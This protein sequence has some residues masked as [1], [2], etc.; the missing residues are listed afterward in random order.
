MANRKL[1]R[2]HRRRCGKSED[3]R[4]CHRGENN[5]DA[6]STRMHTDDDIVVTSTR[7]L[8]Q[9]CS[10]APPPAP[11]PSPRS[12]TPRRALSAVFSPPT[13]PRNQHDFSSSFF[14]AM[15]HASSRNAATQASS[16]AVSFTALERAH[17]T[18]AAP[19]ASANNHQHCASHPRSY[20]L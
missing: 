18:E 12:A 4:G 10:P 9:P 1:E 11:S 20:G 3:A 5:E 13:P 8:P 16:V 15:E 14:R 19:L 2:K 7:M 17:K 6:A